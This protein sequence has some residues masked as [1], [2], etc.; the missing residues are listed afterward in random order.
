V[1]RAFVALGVVLAAGWASATAARSQDLHA[2]WDQRCKECHG[3]AADFAREFLSLKD[4]KLA[5][6][7]H[8]ENLRA[9][10]ASHYSEGILADRIFDML[11]AQVPT[12]PIYRERCFSCHGTAAELVR[13]SVDLEGGKLVGRRRRRPLEQFLVRHGDLKEGERATVLGSLERI[14]RETRGK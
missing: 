5:G 9:F 4:G 2:Y 8:V 3:H 6:R 12:K 7:H 11:A 10:L 14:L 1:R 13:G